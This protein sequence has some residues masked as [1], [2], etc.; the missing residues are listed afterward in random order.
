MLRVSSHV[1]QIALGGKTREEKST[2]LGEAGKLRIVARGEWRLG[3][4][5]EGG[6]DP[7]EGRKAARWMGERGGAMVRAGLRA[8]AEAEAKE[9]VGAGGV[10]GRRV[11]VIGF[12][13]EGSWPEWLE[14]K[15]PAEVVALWRKKTPLWLLEG[16]PNL[17]MAQLAAEIGAKGS[18]ETMRSRAGAGAE[19]RERAVS[20]LARGMERVVGVEGTMAGGVAVVWA[21][22]GEK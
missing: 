6:K 22:E 18:V 1:P 4:E 7:W 8:W 12:G 2:L 19:V 15:T 3:E 10:E 9:G 20:W 17:P 13:L 16:L 5:G 21:M 11:G 14:G